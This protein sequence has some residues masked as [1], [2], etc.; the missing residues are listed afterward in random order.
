LI[1]TQNRVSS[2]RHVNG[3]SI[4]E[5]FVVVVVGIDVTGIVVRVT[6]G[7]VVPHKKSRR[8]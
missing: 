7:D 2:A 5:D 6:D 3:P 4:D 1:K 8:R